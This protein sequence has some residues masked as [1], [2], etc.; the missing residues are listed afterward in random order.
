MMGFGFGMGG[1]GLI[2]MLLFWVG[3]VALAI[4]LVSLLFPAVRNTN[5][6]DHEPVSA[7][8]ILKARY[9]RGE[10]SKDEYQEML[11]TIQQ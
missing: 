4:W 9:A 11:Q 8:E 7:R 6:P 1:F 3:L 10:I 5:E 2:W